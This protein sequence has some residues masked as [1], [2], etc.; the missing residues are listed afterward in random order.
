MPGGGT[1]IEHV[2]YKNGCG[3]LTYPSLIFVVVVVVGVFCAFVSGLVLV[4]NFTVPCCY[5]ERISYLIGGISD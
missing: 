5:R 2:L 3:T 4:D 1:G